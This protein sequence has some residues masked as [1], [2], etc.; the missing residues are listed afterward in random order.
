MANMF[1]MGKSAYQAVRQGAEGAAVRASH[2]APSGM[3]RGTGP[4]VN[5]G[6]RA[7]A[8]ANKAASATASTKST[9]SNSASGLK[10]GFKGTAMPV[11]STPAAAR[12]SRVGTHLNMNKGKYAVGAGAV[13]GGAYLYNRQSDHGGID[14]TD[15]QHWNG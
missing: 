11:D 15:D 5:V 4:A 10:A 8:A 9:I 6:T 3:P 2:A 1:Q 14:T 12:A 7:G 13:G